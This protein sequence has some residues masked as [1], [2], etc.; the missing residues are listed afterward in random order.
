MVNYLKL[1][2][3]R[4]IFEH[5]CFSADEGLFLEK[6]SDFTLLTE[7]WKVFGQSQILQ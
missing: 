6:L 5:H 3:Y 2:T 1:I 7:N 4:P